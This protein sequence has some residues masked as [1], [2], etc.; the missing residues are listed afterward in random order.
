M[1]SSVTWHRQVKDAKVIEEKI[2]RSQAMNV[3]MKW[4]DEDCTEDM[5]SLLVEAIKEAWSMGWTAG[6]EYAMEGM[7]DE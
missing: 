5:V 3:V 4:C 6:A 2:L 7:G 1:S